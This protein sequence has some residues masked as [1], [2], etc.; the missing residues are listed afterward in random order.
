MNSLI[1]IYTHLYIQGVVSLAPSP[2]CEQ[3]EVSD[4]EMS[5]VFMCLTAVPQ[6]PVCTNVDEKYI[7][8]PQRPSTPL[9]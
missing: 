1:F 3:P 4:T 2:V 5:I 6:C 7:Q 8:C 9:S